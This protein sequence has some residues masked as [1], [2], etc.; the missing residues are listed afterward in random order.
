MKQLSIQYEKKKA[1]HYKSFRVTRRVSDLGDSTK[2]G[3]ADSKEFGRLLLS[4]NK[5]IATLKEL[6]AEHHKSIRELEAAMLKGLCRTLVP[7][8]L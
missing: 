2:F 8:M 5:D 1:E 7:T 6:R 3:I 4:L